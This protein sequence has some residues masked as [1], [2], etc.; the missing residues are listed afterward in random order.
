[1]DFE[2]APE[3]SP[4]SSAKSLSQK[5]FGVPVVSLMLA[6]GAGAPK[7][8]ECSPKSTLCRLFLLVANPQMPKSQ[9]GGAAISNPKGPKIKKQILL[10]IFNLAWKSQS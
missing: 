4:E 5:F 7:H 6:C 10:E 2:I 1:M 3:S 9:I 8:T